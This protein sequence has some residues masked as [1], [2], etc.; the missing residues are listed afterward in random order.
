MLFKPCTIAVCLIG[1]SAALNAQYLFLSTSPTG[2]G[3]STGANTAT[4]TV[5]GGSAGFYLGPDTG[6]EV[7]GSF[8]GIGPINYT[9]ASTAFPITV[10]LPSGTLTGTITF[11]QNSFED[12]GGGDV[13][14]SH[15]GAF[16]AGITIT[17]GTGA[18]AGAS[19]SFGT[20]SSNFVN[21]T[22]T[23]GGT[24]G[25]DCPG[26]F[27]SGFGIGGSGVGSFTLPGPP[28][29]STPIPGTLIL[30]ACGMVLIGWFYRRSLAVR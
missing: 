19:G 24:L 12:T 3:V 1:M 5:V 10:T 22:C 14:T 23:S 6:T 8:S 13:F 29:P 20:E 21:V 18:Y 27:T 25:A 28:P 30:A 11:L 15:Y 9:S 26:N 4:F 16:N 2:A 17:G 7:L